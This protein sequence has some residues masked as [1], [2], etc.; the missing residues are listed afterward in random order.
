MSVLEEQKG[1]YKGSL[2]EYLRSLWVVVNEYKDLG[3]N[4]NQLASIIGHAFKTEPP[5][6]DN[7]W[8]S[9]ENPLTWNYRDNTYVIEKL[10]GHQVKIVATNVDDF[11]I[12]KHTLLFQIADLYRMRDN[13]LKD[14]YRY[15]GIDS[16]T[17]NTWY[18]FDVFTYLECGTRGMDDN[19]GNAS[20]STECDWVTLAFILELGRIY[21]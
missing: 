6:F 12:L 14:K 18:N 9:F 5:P 13:Q 11:D 21:E 10:E 1:S 4:F 15:Y 20:A 19:T 7:Q 16:P 2:E 3:L 17:G 8:L